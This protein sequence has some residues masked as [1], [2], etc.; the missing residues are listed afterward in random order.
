MPPEVARYNCEKQDH[1]LEKALDHRLI[2]LAQPALE[3]GEKVSDR[4]ADPQHQPHRRHDALVARSRSATATKG[5]PTT[6]STSASRARPARASARS[7]RKGVTID[8]DRRHQ[9]L[10]RQGAVGRAHLGAALAQVPRRPA[11]E[12]H[13]RQRRALRRDRRRGV[14]PR[15][16]GRALRGAEF[17]RAGGGRGRGRPRLRIHDRRHGGGARR[18]RPQLRAPACRAASPTCSTRTAR[19]RAAAIRRW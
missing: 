13:H 12:H 11:R 4:N 17:R 16:R 6:P 7:S 1:G 9:R 3:R 14:F 19:S 15:R 18:D 10:L 8:L 2:E 5:C